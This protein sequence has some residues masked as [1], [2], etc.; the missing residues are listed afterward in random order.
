MM[1]AQGINGQAIWLGDESSANGWKYGMVSVAAFLAQTMKE[2]IKYDACDE[3]NWDATTNYPASNA[4]GQLGQSYQD[5]NCAAGEEHMA[6]EV[7]PDM[8]IRANTHANWYGAPPAFFCAPK[9]LLQ[10]SP[11]WSYSGA[12]CAPNVPRDVDMT[13]DEYLQYIVSDDTCRD[14][15]GQKDGEFTFAGCGAEGCGNAPAPLFGKPD[16]RTDVEG[17]CWWGRGVIQTMPAA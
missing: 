10:K 9:Y 7:D 14:Y 17:C 1:H 13:M 12:W 16:P 2:T 8:M 3:N 5:Y 15:K 11:R 4:C 6:C